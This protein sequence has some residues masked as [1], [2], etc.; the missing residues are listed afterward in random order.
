MVKFHSHFFAISFPSEY[1]LGI[2]C[3]HTRQ[4]L[5]DLEIFIYPLSTLD[6][7]S[8]IQ[9]RCRLTLSSFKTRLA[10]ATMGFVLFVTCRFTQSSESLHRK[11]P[12]TAQGPC[13]S[14]IFNRVE[15][16]MDRCGTKW[17]VS[18]LEPIVQSGSVRQAYQICSHKTFINQGGPA[19]RSKSITHSAMM[20]SR[21]SRLSSGISRAVRDLTR[22]ENREKLM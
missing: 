18:I 22:W 12:R 9:V 2:A 19:Y 16:T 11:T 21:F 17:H 15:E 20:T 3:G 10:N 13:P 8:Q 1:P 6:L 14:D 7:P 5:I 4:N